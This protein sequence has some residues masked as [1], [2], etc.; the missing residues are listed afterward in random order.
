MLQRRSVQLLNV[1]VSITDIEAEAQDEL[2][3]LI[4]YDELP[5][6]IQLG[7]GEMQRTIIVPAS[8]QRII[9]PIVKANG[10]KA[11][12]SNEDNEWT[13]ELKRGKYRAAFTICADGLEHNIE[14]EFE[15]RQERPYVTWIQNGTVKL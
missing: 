5:R 11:I 12:A 15:V 3:G 4:H 14:R 9:V 1:R 8:R 10:L 2:S 7:D 6:K 13:I